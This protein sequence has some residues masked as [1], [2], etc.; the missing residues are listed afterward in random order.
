MEVVFHTTQPNPLVMPNLQIIWIYNLSGLRTVFNKVYGEGHFGSLTHI[1]V[2]FCPKLVSL[3]TSS[4]EGFK[5]LE[6]LTI[7][8]CVRLEEVFADKSRTTSDAAKNQALLFPKL[9]TLCLWELS[10]LKSI[11]GPHVYFPNLKKII[12]GGCPKLHKLPNHFNSVGLAGQQP[13]EIKGEF[14]WGRTRYE[15]CKK[16][17]HQEWDRESFMAAKLLIFGACLNLIFKLQ[18]VRNLLQSRLYT[19]ES[20]IWQPLSTTLVAFQSVSGG[21]GVY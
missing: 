12:V 7:R 4:S 21:K 11:S 17:E 20:Q 6:T 18:L 2:E 1:S 14:E 19:A 13:I 5:S 9:H 16:E 8:F 10:S 3:V 15:A